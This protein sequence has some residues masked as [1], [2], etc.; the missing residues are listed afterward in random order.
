VNTLFEIVTTRLAERRAERDQARSRPPGRA[1]RCH[2]RAPVFFNNSFCL[3]CHATLGY[4]PALLEVRSFQPGPVEG[5]WSLVPHP[6]ESLPA[7]LAPHWHRCGNFHSPAGC[8][9][10]VPATESAEFCPACRLNRTIPDLSDPQS[11]ERWRKIE[12]AKRRLVAQLLELGL[13]V[14]SKSDDPWHGLA[15][16]FLAT[17]P[18][19]PRVMTSHAE[20]VITLNIEEAD[21]V[22][23]E[24]LRT[25]MNEPDRTLLGHFRHE[26][27][28]YYW[29]RLIAQGPWLEPFRRVFGDERADYAAAL[30]WNYTHPP[31]PDWPLRHVSAYASVH[32]W[33]DWA[34]T[35]AH[36]LQI[37]DTLATAVGFGLGASDVDFEAAPFTR[38]ALHDP[39][40]PGAE[41]F[42][43]LINAWIELT[44]VLNELAR[45]LG[46]RDLCPFVLSITAVAKLHFVHLVVTG[47]TPGQD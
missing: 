31:P 16:D 1:N 47:A 28:H 41:A 6:D 15:F 37:V 4:V 43:L 18:G 36:Y 32:P 10:M 40:H 14:P 29:D 34:E 11:A 13:P 44:A 42:L 22:V 24:Q 2:C 21:D 20:G 7:A 25:A 23:R 38:E 46:Q 5:Q 19:Q 3:A 9:W 26:I 30:A 8:N 45:S 27:A 35:W 33:E 39:E 17:L 12:I